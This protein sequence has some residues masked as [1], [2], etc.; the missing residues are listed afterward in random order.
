MTKGH[1]GGVQASLETNPTYCRQC[2]PTSDI[3]PAGIEQPIWRGS[4]LPKHWSP[5]PHH[6][7]NTHAHIHTQ[8]SSKDM[9]KHFFPPRR[10]R[11][12]S[13]YELYSNS[14]LTF[15]S[16]LAPSTGGKLILQLSFG[17]WESAVT[18]FRQPLLGR[19]VGL[20]IIAS[21]NVLVV[22]VLKNR[23]ARHI[24]ICILLTV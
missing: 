14:Q 23:S 15:R 5:I 2:R 20:A 13:G 6:H 19:K 11:F 1:A 22:S 3:G 9:V 18:H 24:L 16:P 10:F 12:T 17:D 8:N 21:Y 7:T 4:V